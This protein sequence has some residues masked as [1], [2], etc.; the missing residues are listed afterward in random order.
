MADSLC[1]SVSLLLWACRGRPSRRDV[2]RSGIHHPSAYLQLL[3]WLQAKRLEIR[4]LINGQDFAGFFC[5]GDQLVSFSTSLSERLLNDDCRGS[6]SRWLLALYLKTST[7]HASQTSV[8][9][10]QNDRECLYALPQL[11]AQLPCLQKI[12][13][14]SDSALH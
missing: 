7:N 13:L 12:H 3:A 6:V 9:I 11:Q 10:P 4:T 2:A 1:R 8:P 14:V 5:Y